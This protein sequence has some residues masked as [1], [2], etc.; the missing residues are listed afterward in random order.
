MLRGAGRDELLLIR[1]SL[2][3]PLRLWRLL[4]LRTFAAL[5][6]IFLSLR[7]RGCAQVKAFVIFPYCADRIALERSLTEIF[8]R[9]DEVT[10]GILNDHFSF[11]SCPVAVPSPYFPWTGID[12]H[13]QVLQA[14]D[15]W[16][17]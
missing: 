12:W 2:C 7:P 5:R 10:I 6:E 9:H 13:L 14:A 8:S 17:D 4:N 11:T 16:I 3:D 1:A 15:D